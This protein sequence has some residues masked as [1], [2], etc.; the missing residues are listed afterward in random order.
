MQILILDLSAPFGHFKVPY[1]TTSPLT[2]PVPPKTAVYGILGAILGIDKNEYLGYF[3]DNECKISLG[4]KNSIKKFHISENLINTKNVKLFSRMNSMKSAPHTQIN[5]EFLKNT[6]FRLYVYFI[7][8]TII[9]NLEEKIAN[10]KSVY[11]ISFGLSEC[12]ANYEYI[13]KFSIR[14]IKSLKKKY[15]EISSILPF[16]NISSSEDLQLVEGGKKYLK[17]HLPL[18]MKTDRELEKTGDFLIETNGKVIKVKL[19]EYYRIN[20]LNENIVLF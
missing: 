16:D 11:T 10:H 15:V 6:K 7:D 20:E 5:I 13:G 2:F 18:E 17:V 4:I 8:K 3:K 19:N 12:I 1:T 9:N 14:N